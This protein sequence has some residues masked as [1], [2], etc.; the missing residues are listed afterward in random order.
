MMPQQMRPQNMMPM[1]FDQNMAPQNMMP[2][3]GGAKSTG[4][5]QFVGD[6]DFFF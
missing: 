4:K 2:Q 6:K 3:M 5:Y 1:G